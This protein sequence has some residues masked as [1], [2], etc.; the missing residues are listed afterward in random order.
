MAFL[1]RHDASSFNNGPPTVF[2]VATIPKMK[3]E[4]TLFSL[5]SSNTS[6]PIF[7]K[8]YKEINSLEVKPQQDLA[9][10]TGGDIS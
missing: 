1:L 4:G 7:A 8:L 9:A 2:P 6:D 5:L 10:L 3:P